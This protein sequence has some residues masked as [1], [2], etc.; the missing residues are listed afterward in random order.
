MNYFQ[1]YGFQI[2]GIKF[3]ATKIIPE[4]TANS[5]NGY[6]LTSSG[7]NDG[8]LFN[9]TAN[10]TASFANFNTR[11]TNFEYWIKYQLPQSEIV[12]MLDIGA[13]TGESNRMP[14]RFK[15]LAS[16]DNTNWNLLLEVSDLTRWYDGETRQYY[17][18]N[19]TAYKYYK[20]IPIELQT[21]EFRIARLR[22]YNISEN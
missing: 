3:T 12:N 1:L 16:N 9:L 7:T 10:S 19:T 8:A 21:S 6:V 11:D 5:L 17:L 18:T 2:G 20:F 4:L 22:L 14:L 15:I 13:C